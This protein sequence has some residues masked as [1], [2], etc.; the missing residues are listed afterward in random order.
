MKNIL[1]TLR[2]Y[3]C[4]LSENPY[5]IIRVS[6]GK[7]T[8][9]TGKPKAG[10]IN[11]CQEIVDRNNLNHGFIYAVKAQQ[12]NILKGSFELDKNVLQQARKVWSFY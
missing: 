12:Q 4:K 11:D 10:F 6:G 5:F 9:F 2:M 1:L 8:V 3:A 7:A